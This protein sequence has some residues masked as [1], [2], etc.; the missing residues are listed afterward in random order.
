MGSKTLLKPIISSFNHFVVVLALFFVSGCKHPEKRI[1][2]TAPVHV[3]A[4]LPAEVQVIADEYF[5]LAKLRG[6]TFKTDISAGMGTLED[7]AIGVC[8]WATTWREIEYDTEWWSEAPWMK[9]V[10][11]V[12]HEMTHCHCSRLH[13]Y[14]KDKLYPDPKLD[15]IMKIFRTSKSPVPQEGYMVDGCP[16]SIMHPIITDLECFEKHYAYYVDEM[17]A[18]CEAY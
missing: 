18:R 8:T 17:F 15:L 14:A 1:E 3:G 13:D 11:L 9:K 4:V 7:D 16:V 10:A 6:I 2:K 12:Y 5:K